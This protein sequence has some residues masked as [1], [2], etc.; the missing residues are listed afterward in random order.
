[1]IHQLPASLL[2]CTGILWLF[3]IAMETCPCIDGL[4]RFTY[5][6]PI[7]N[8]EEFHFPKRN[9]NHQMAPF[10]FM[11]LGVVFF[12][13][14]S[15]PDFFFHK[16]LAF[17]HVFFFFFSGPWDRWTW[18]QQSMDR[19]LWVPFNA[20]GCAFTSWVWSIPSAASLRRRSEMVGALKHD[21]KFCE[22][23]IYILYYIYIYVI[24]I[25]DIMWSLCDHYTLIIQSSSFF[26]FNK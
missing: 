11:F 2:S 8:G 20:A 18:S 23:Y 6:L 9:K 22:C 7:K 19:S 1:M 15:S 3:N 12:P 5:D 25:C 24:Y 17:S 10:F 13:K 21:W 4:W 14:K 16:M 26:F